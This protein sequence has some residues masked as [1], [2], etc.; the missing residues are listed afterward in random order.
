MDDMDAA[1]RRDVSPQLGTCKRALE[2]VQ[3]QL[4]RDQL[5]FT[6]GEHPQ[7]ICRRAP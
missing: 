2:L 4:G 6:R 7:H 3:Q 1:A 5:K